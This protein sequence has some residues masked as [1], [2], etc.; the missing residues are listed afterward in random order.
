MVTNTQGVTHTNQFKLTIKPPEQKIYPDD[1]T[2]SDNFGTDISISGDFLIAGAPFD[3]DLGSNSGAAY[4]YKRTVNGWQFMEK[5]QASDGAADD[6]FGYN[7]AL[8]G[9]YAI[10]SAHYDDVGAFQKRGHFLSPE[11]AAHTSP[12]QRPGNA[13]G[14]TLQ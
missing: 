10:I 4:I 11:R 13:L 1:L 9:D 7:V 2:A 12:G 3:D 8:S 6:R 5:I 14:N